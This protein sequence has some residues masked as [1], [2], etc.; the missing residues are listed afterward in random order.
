MQWRNRSFWGLAM[1]SMIK[2]DVTTS[3]PATWDWSTFA[4][5]S[6]H[7]ATLWVPSVLANYHLKSG[8]YPPQLLMP[9]PRPFLVSSQPS[10]PSALVSTEAVVNKD[11]V[12]L[13]SL[14][15]Q[16]PILLLSCWQNA[17]KSDGGS[18]SAMPEAGSPRHMCSHWGGPSMM[19]WGVISLNNSTNLI[20]I[21][22]N[23]TTV[24]YMG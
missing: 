7:A 14:L 1:I 4:T 15:R 2:S 13:F 16:I 3:R 5:G 6:G 17:V 11:A 10:K 8:R 19:G 23:M 21:K 24:H 12:S 20:I 22:G 18:E 9:I